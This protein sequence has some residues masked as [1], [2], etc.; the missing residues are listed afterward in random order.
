MITMPGGR[1]F[2]SRAVWPKRSEQKI[3]S[4][5][6]GII[7]MLKPGYYYLQSRYY[8]P[9]W[10]RFINADEPSVMLENQENVLQHNLFAYCVNNPILYVDLQ[11][12]KAIKVYVHWVNLNP[13]GF[14]VK[15]SYLFLSKRYCASFSQYIIKRHGKNGKYVKMNALRISA[16]ILGH[17]VGYLLSKG[18]L[19]ICKYIPIANRNSVINALNTML[20]HFG[21]QPYNRCAEINVNNDEKTALVLLYSLTWKVWPTF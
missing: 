4:A 21:N 9:E 7:T 11:G 19:T 20:K 8:S 18:M 1:F 14:D 12:S 15:V 17:T 5:A 13:K 16:E 6:A 3:P 2:R 10:C